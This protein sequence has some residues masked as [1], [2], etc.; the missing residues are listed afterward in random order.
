MS[1]RELVLIGVLNTLS[2]HVIAIIPDLADCRLTE[3]D[4]KPGNITL[5]ASEMASEFTGAGL[6]EVV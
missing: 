1:L 2:F 6:A 5:R 4:S 3:V